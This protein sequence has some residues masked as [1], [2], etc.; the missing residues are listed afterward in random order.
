VVV[1]PLAGLQD[2]GEDPTHLVPLL[3]FHSGV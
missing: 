2:F 3:L 1:P